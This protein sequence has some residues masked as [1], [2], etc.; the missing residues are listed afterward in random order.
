MDQ[1]VGELLLLLRVSKHHSGA[2]MADQTV[3]QVLLLR[4]GCG[5]LRSPGAYTRE[6]RERGSKEAS[7]G[8][9]C[10]SI[11]TSGQGQTR[12]RVRS[13]QLRT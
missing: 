7:A 2:Q 9:W 4:R 10:I 5:E 8:V 6:A 12:Q 11:L 13:A 3:G 1:T